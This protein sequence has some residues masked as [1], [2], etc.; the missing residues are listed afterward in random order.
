MGI[1]GVFDT[2]GDIVGVLLHVELGEGLHAGDI[3]LDHLQLVLGSTRLV[4]VAKLDDRLV[5]EEAFVMAGTP[6]D[7]VGGLFHVDLGEEL[8]V[9]D[10]VL[11]HRTCLA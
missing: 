7:I 3:V 8:H 5:S 10:L 4:G 2:A 1:L 11:V 6:G 9:G